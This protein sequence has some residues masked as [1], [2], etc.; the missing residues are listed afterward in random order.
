MYCVSC[1]AQEKLRRGR[2]MVW[3]AKSTEKHEKHLANRGLEGKWRK[4]YM[5]SGL[6]SMALTF[7][8][9]TFSFIVETKHL[10]LEE[11]MLISCYMNTLPLR[12]VVLNLLMLRPS[13]CGDPSYKIILLLPLKCKFASAL[14]HHV[15]I[16]YARYLIHDPRLRTLALED[17]ESLRGKGFQ[18]PRALQDHWK[19]W[20]PAHRQSLSQTFPLAART[21][22]APTP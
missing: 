21:V 9:T 13:C 16:L 8:N 10:S 14:N 20:A 6:K 11:R 7:W 18:S 19:P 15:N 12:E 2:E 3:A 5:R 17:G 1:A 22:E 4:G